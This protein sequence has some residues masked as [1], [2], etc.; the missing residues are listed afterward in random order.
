[1]PKDF[2]FVHP[3]GGGMAKVKSHKLKPVSK[4]DGV[5]SSINSAARHFN[6][7]IRTIRLG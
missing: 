2:F 7:G 3:D 1:M 4:P 5:F 6:V